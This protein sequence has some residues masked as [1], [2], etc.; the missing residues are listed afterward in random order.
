MTKEVTLTRGYVALVSDADYERV[1]QHK[2]HVDR[3]RPNLSYATTWIAG[4]N[5]RMHRFLL[6]AIKGEEVDHIDG[7]GLNNTRENIQMVSRQTNSI[8]REVFS[9][10]KTGYAG[11][12]QFRS[13]YRARIGYN[14]GTVFVGVFDTLEEA[15][16]ARDKELVK[17]FGEDAPMS[18]IPNHL[19]HN[20]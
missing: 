15:A 17:L 4:K 18:K 7:D 1:A 14:Y 19:A 20:S 6:Y 11:I 16:S 5:V 8:K 10:N 13:G 9:H 3:L 12:D 2:W